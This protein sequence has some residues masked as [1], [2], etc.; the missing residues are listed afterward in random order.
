MTVIDVPY[1]TAPPSDL[2]LSPFAAVVF[3]DVCK[4]PSVAPRVLRKVISGVQMM[5]PV[6]ARNGF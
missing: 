5:L 4:V 1:L 3:A 6:G 2:D